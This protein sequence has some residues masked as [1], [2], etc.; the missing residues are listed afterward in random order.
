MECTLCPRRCR[1]DRAR[2][3]G[4]C[5]EQGEASVTR[6]ALHFGEEPVISGTRGSGTVFFSGC[7]LH[8]VFCQNRD[9]SGG[10]A[11]L[12]HR[13][14]A[15][16]VSPERLRE[17]YFKLIDAGAHNI[18]LVTPTHFSDVIAKSLEPGLPV[19]VIW[20]SSGYESVET[21]RRLE[22]LISVYMPDYK[23]SSPLLAEE[24][25]NAP[26]YPSVAHAA[27]CEMIRQT[28]SPVFDGDGMLVRGTLI[29]HLVLPGAGKNTRGVIDAVAELPGGS[30][31]FSLMAQYTPPEG[32][33]AE[34]PELGRGITEAEYNRA[35][36]YLALSGI[37]HC[38]LQGLD[39][40]TEEML[41]V[42]DGTGTV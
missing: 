15:V 20:N 11:R 24:Y 16:H 8:C 9:I 13:A 32:I 7:S 35:A 34:Y 2:L 10:S 21:L 19:P 37:E 23:Y 26:D 42:F 39:S 38:Y 30:F 41:P 12:A 27:V 28:G 18:N 3:S 6:A 29:R 1:A 25:S 22:G 4:Y 17:L 5:G 14:N 33:G 36:D 40:A 31:I